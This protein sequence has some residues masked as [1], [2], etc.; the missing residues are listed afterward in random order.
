MPHRRRTT[1][2]CPFAA[3][4]ALLAILGVASGFWAVAHHNLDHHATAA[5][6][7]DAHHSD[8]PAPPDAPDA[9]DAPASPAESDCP[10]A[11]LIAA[12][13]TLSVASMPAAGL[14]DVP[15]PRLLSPLTDYTRHPRTIDLTAWSARPPPRA[16]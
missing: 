7:R 13:Q 6:H 5:A 15:A 8:A 9:P 16:A 10:T 3:A 1:R 2:S 14:L 11:D 12:S 4:L